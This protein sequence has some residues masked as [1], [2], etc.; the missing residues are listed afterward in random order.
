MSAGPTF[1][2]Q[3]ERDLTQVANQ[4]R[5]KKELMELSNAP[6]NMTDKVRN[7]FNTAWTL[8]NQQNN[9][10]AFTALENMLSHIA[11][12]D[13]TLAQQMNQIRN[14]QNLAQKRQLLQNALMN[15][16]LISLCANQISADL[17][18]T[19]PG[20]PMTNNVMELM[21]GFSERA[22]QRASQAS[23]GAGGIGVAIYDLIIFLLRMV[24]DPYLAAQGRGSLGF[25][26]TH[27]SAS[28]SPEGSQPGSSDGKW[29]DAKN[30]LMLNV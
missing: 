1:L 19:D 11:Q 25:M 24:L 14:C 18:Q 10:Q 30:K 20:D 2:P 21:K 27:S 17:R 28:S 26:N 12:S 4:L 7:V 16:H 3:Y 15:D 8:A 22:T 9:H 5:A 6:G 23:Y 13:Q 29:W